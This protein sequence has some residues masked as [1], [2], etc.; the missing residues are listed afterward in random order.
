MS[1]I[2]NGQPQINA[3]TALTSGQVPIARG[4]TSAASTATA[5]TALGLAIGS[6]VETFT[7]NNVTQVPIGGDISA[8]VTAA[9]AG[10]TLVLAAGTYTITSAIDI[11][12]RLNIVG[13]GGTATNVNCATDNITVFSITVSNVRISSLTINNSG[14][15]ATPRGIKFDGTAGTVLSDCVVEHVEINMT[16][17]A[18]NQ[19]G[20]V[21]NDAWGTLQDVVIDCSG[22]TSAYGLSI[23]A[24]ATCEAD[25]TTYMHVT[26]VR[27]A[28]VTNAY[29][30][31][32]RDTGSSN[33]TIIKCYKC[34]FQ[35]KG[36][37]GDNI[38]FLGDGDDSVSVFENSTFEGADYDI[39][40]SNSATVAAVG[41]SLANNLT[42]GTITYSGVNAAGGFKTA[43]NIDGVHRAAD[44]TAAV[45][46]G[47]Y[48]TGIGAA[49][50]GSMTI[51][52]G[53]ITAITEAAD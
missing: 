52:D 30:F 46:D 42:S 21:W 6:D 41:C 37:S 36:G 27:V 10:D 13:Q 19:F 38:G 51:K 17:A 11:A 48:T 34:S 35:A 40:Q 23:A 5:R 15:G 1:I 33:D 32:N 28:A 20:I 50:N 14:A 53:I 22:A 44:A 16:G 18:T 31:R 26:T 39:E 24:T 12:K 3:T 9:T 47:S 4:G 45:A 49:T 25:I 2:V 29:A 8:Y 43:G 7:D